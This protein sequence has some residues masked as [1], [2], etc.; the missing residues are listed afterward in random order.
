MKYLLISILTIINVYS[1]E[2]KVEVPKLTVSKI[3]T[4]DPCSLTV[5]M[6]EE[7]IRTGYLN[8]SNFEFLYSYENKKVEGGYVSWNVEDGLYLSLNE[9]KIKLYLENNNYKHPIDIGLENCNEKYPSTM[10]M[11]VCSDKIS[12]LWDQEL[13]R[14]YK[15]IPKKLKAEVKEMQ[16]A[17]IVYR[18]KT[19]NAYEKY[20]NS[21]EGSMWGLVYQGKVID[22]VRSQAL[23]LG[24]FERN[25]IGM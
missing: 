3:K 15:N 17:W 24:R 1:K 19:K 14:S 16:K 10:G 12:D 2:I 22:L 21:F 6:G 5:T 23:T 20:Y 8:C 9:K 11:N 4:H 18:D 25:L 7:S 13:N